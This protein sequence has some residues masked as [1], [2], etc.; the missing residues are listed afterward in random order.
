MQRNKIW[1]ARHVSKYNHVGGLT[2]SVGERGGGSKKKKGG[3]P[4]LCNGMSL[5]QLCSCDVQCAI[6]HLYSIVKVNLVVFCK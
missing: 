1:G 2:F 5:I 3:P 4:A 6:Y